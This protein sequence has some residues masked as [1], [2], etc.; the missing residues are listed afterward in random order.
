MPLSKK[1]RGSEA[2]LAEHVIAWFRANQWAVYQE[3]P[4]CGSAADIVVT[5]GP[6]VGVAETKQSLGLDVLCQAHS[7]IGK[8]NF[9]WCAIWEPKRSQNRFGKTVAKQF[10]IGVFHVDD[11]AWNIDPVNLVLPAQFMRRIDNRLRDALRPEMMDGKYGKAGTQSGGRFTPFRETCEGLLAVV[12]DNPGIELKPAIKL[13]KKHHYASDSA[14]R[15]NLK[16]MIER[17]VVRNVK[18]IQ[19]GKRLILFEAHDN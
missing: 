15:V 4:F 1:P 3:V 9:V 10:G 16:K 8:A 12:R 13:L 11:Q 2:E 5:K 6:V 14:A 18:M 7:W 17:G 19:E